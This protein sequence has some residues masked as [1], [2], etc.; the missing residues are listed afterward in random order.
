MI[1]IC[2]KEVYK[3]KKYRFIS[4][5]TALFFLLF[6]IILPNLALLF[7]IVKDSGPPLLKTKVL[8]SLLGGIKTNFT[9]VNQI[10][11]F[12]ISILFGIYVSFFLFFLEKR[13]EIVAGSGAKSGIVGF[14]SGIFGV[15]CASCGSFILSS[16]FSTAGAVSIIAFL[17]LKGLE[18]SL[19]STF[20]LL[21]SIYIMAK[22]IVKSG[23]CSVAKNK[24]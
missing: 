15:G 13:R 9:P 6:A 24:P 7:Q 18:F 17:P 16:L 10:F 22:N 2:I 23:I 19:L 4:I 3:S 12:A 20:F 1:F 5:F 8:V 21:F 11:A 14:I